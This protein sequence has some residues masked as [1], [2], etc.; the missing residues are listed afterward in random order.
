MQFYLQ[1]IA[2]G[3]VLCTAEVVFLNGFLGPICITEGA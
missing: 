3:A 1:G 2:A